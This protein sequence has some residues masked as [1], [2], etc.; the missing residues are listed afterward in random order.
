MDQLEREPGAAG[1]VW[2]HIRFCCNPGQ[3]EHLGFIFFNF[4]D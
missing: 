3:E 4:R 1:E 2:C